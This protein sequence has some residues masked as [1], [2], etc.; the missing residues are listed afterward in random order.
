ML[1]TGG[2]CADIDPL[3]DYEFR[4]LETIPKISVEGFADGFDTSSQLPEDGFSLTWEA[5]DDK[6]NNY[7]TLRLSAAV[8]SQALPKR[9]Q[10]P[11][12][13]FSLTCEASDDKENNNPTLQPSATLTQ[14]ALPKRSQLPEDGFSLT[15]L[16]A[17]DNKE[18]NLLTLRPNAIST[19]K[20][21][22]KRKFSAN[23]SETPTNSKRVKLSPVSPLEALQKQQIA[24]L[25]KQVETFERIESVLVKKNEIE[26]KKI[27]LLDEI[28]SCIHS[29]PC[30]VF[31]SD[32]D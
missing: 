13:G 14:Q 22:P 1:K 5:S 23:V 9:S 4:M 2:G 21:Q 24:I 10:L 12:D 8:T 16:S 7:P 25:Q 20:G 30:K 26:E 15:L 11:E 18:N 28:L 31:E 17:G 29:K 3:S 27:A 6:E 19:P 32:S